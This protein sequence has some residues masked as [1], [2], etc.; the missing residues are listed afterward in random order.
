M[1]YIIAA[2]VAA[3]A[4]AGWGLKSA[5]EDSAKSRLELAEAN[6]QLRDA[7]VRQKAVDETVGKMIVANRENAKKLDATLT[8]VRNIKPESGD[9]NESIDCLDRPVPAALSRSL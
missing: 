3:L 7:D 9:T 5:W 2:L 4:V 8:A 1:Y 6:R